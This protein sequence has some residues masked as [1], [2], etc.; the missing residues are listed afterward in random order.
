MRR[1]AGCSRGFLGV[2][3]NPWYLFF[4]KTDL[5]GGRHAELS[6]TGTRSSPQCH[7]QG[8]K[9]KAGSI[10]RARRDLR[11]HRLKNSPTFQR[12]GRKNTDTEQPQ[13]IK[14][15]HLPFSPF[16]FILP[17]VPEQQTGAPSSPPV[18]LDTDVPG[19]CCRAGL[20][21]LKPSVVKG[22]FVAALFWLQPRIS[23]S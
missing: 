10:Q 14:D 3:R 20:P 22:G 17:L 11:S 18:F 23:G 2:P 19:P 13:I 5:K 21:R 8:W 16:F 4:K 7:A 1:G 12:A 6:V 9:R 15:R